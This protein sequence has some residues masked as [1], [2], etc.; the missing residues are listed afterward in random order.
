MYCLEPFPHGHQPSNLQSE[1]QN[2]L[3][4]DHVERGQ[5]SPGEAVLQWRGAFSFQMANWTRP[6]IRADR[7][8]GALERATEACQ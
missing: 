1:M 4:V 6:A 7:G 5:R 2:S 3:A 8:L